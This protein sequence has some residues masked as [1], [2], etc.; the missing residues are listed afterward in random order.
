M[1]LGPSPALS[2]YVYRTP[3][4]PS[5]MVPPSSSPAWAWSLSPPFLSYMGLVHGHAPFPCAG[6]RM[7]RCSLSMWVKGSL[8][9]L[10]HGPFHPR[11]LPSP[12]CARLAPLS[13]MRQSPSPPSP[14]CSRLPPLSCMACDSPMVVLNVHGFPFPPP[15][16]AP[17]LHGLGPV[18]SFS[19]FPLHVRGGMTLSLPPRL[20]GM[21]PS[22][23][24]M[25]SPPP[26]S[27]AW[28]WSMGSV[29]S[30]APAHE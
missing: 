29:P 5:D 18:P 22:H 24:C 16:W 27:P 10:E 8:P 30:P 4:S 19:M 15:A 25:G 11:A 14:A 9:P 20:H 13:C 7:T 12:A 26:S 6:E 2:P 17:L 1:W 21:V 23:S 3:L 28:A